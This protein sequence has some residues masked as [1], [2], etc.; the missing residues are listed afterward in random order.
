M[1]AERK[2]FNLRSAVVISFAVKFGVLLLGVAIMGFTQSR[3]QLTACGSTSPGNPAIYSAPFG[4]VEA[5]TDYRDLYLR[6]LV[7]PFLGGKSAYNLPIVYNYPPP[8]L[9]LLS[10]ASFL[11]SYIWSAAIPLVLFDALTVIP[12]YLLAKDFLFR[13]SSK[14][15]FAVA[16]LWIFNPINLFYNDLMWLNTGPTTF[17]LMFSI[18]FL[19]KKNYTLSSVFLGISTSLKQT[20]ILLFPIFLIWMLRSSSLPRKKILAY[21][22]LYAAILVI[23]STPYLFQ[24]PQSY[25]WALQLPILGNPP[26]TSGNIPTTFVYDLSQPTR[27]TTF[28]G[29]VRFANLTSLAVDTYYALNYIF[30]LSYLVMLI[31]FAVGL[32]NFPKVLS[33]SFG[34]LA[35]KISG[36]KGVDDGEGTPLRNRLFAGL[37]FSTALTA[38]NLMLYCLVAVLLFLSF[39]GRGVYKYYF[40]GITPLAL[41]L[42]SSKKSGILFEI[43][44]AVLI[45]IPREATPWMAVLLIT[46]IPTLI[47]QG[48]ITA[49]NQVITAQPT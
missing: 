41:P 9:Y 20:A 19:L 12:V 7:N 27:L 4:D 37:N 24:N 35:R 36:K 38:N 17:F 34:W 3:T 44:S 28:I 1:A 13:G 26:G 49:S 16:L 31:Q 48:R 6:C 22:V 43:F 8:F 2:L 15:A 45:F 25:L 5:Y 30:A 47:Q 40:A 42:F 23:I 14:P 32:R 33:L 21:S 29:L 10:A 11:L 46:M 39:F 18:Y